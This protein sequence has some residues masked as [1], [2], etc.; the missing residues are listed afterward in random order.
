M[1]KIGSGRMPTLAYIERCD[2]T[3]KFTS[4]GFPATA[5]LSCL[6]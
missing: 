2:H 4:R 6:F 5:R 1:K 3:S